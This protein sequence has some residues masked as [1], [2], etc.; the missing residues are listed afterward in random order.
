[1]TASAVDH[2]RDPR[3]G[4][5]VLTAVISLLMALHWGVMLAPGAVVLVLAVARADLVSRPVVWWAMAAVWFTA[6]AIA[7]NRMED[8]V[9]LFTSWL[10]A[11]AIALSRADLEDVVRSAAWHARL[12][13]GI[14]FAAA[15]GWKLF[16]G[17]FATGMTLRLF[18]VTD[19]RF[20]PLARALGLGADR[21]HTDREH[22]SALLDGSITTVPL[23]DHT[24][25]M[26]RLTVIAVSTL[27]LEVVVAVS[28]LA[29]D[30]SRLAGL[31]LPSV[32]V[33]G[34]TTYAIVPV[35]PFAAL[36]GVLALAAARWRRTAM[37]IVPALVL[38][39]A[40]R[41]ALLVSDA[42]R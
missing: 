29:P 36:L 14:A 31:R 12:L 40:V 26:W 41:F 38:V 20:E 5:P 27:L 16:F 42:V 10:V 33:F 21:L 17:E 24:E 18:L 34:V 39:A 35:L 13:I 23:G 7:Q 2:L 1:M 28:H 37:W 30:R 19:A 15:V 11:L 25:A 32:A 8:H 22:V 3:L 9:H 4:M 6:L